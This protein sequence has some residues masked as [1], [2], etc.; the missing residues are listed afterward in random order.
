MARLKPCP[1]ET[2]HHHLGETNG[3]GAALV[4]G[5]GFSSA[6]PRGDLAAACG[7]RDEAEEAGRVE[8]ESY[9]EVLKLRG[10]R[11]AAGALVGEQADVFAVGKGFALGC[12][13]GAVVGAG[14][15]AA[16]RERG[17]FVGGEAEGGRGGRETE[18]QQQDEGD[19]ATH[20]GVVYMVDL[21]GEVALCAMLT[22]HPNEQDRSPGHRVERPRRGFS[23]RG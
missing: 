16:G 12:G 13:H 20:L 2:E 6:S 7:C 22:F 21:A 8:A 15:A 18:G 3:R 11:R 14:A 9:V 23:T 17:V 19:E 4:T 10:G 1:F 5:S